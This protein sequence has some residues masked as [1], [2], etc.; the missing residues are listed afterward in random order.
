MT[1]LRQRLRAQVMEISGGICEWPLCSGRGVEL[2]HLHSVGAGGR[3]SADTL[4]NV[5]AF[6]WDHARISDGEFGQGGMDQY[7]EAHRVLFGAAQWQVSWP[8]SPGWEN[9]LAWERAE[10]LRIYLQT[11]RPGI[12]G[13]DQ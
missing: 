7:R 2:A 5:A 1:T 4:G 11:V 9:S 10:A 6:C 13:G 8:G 3:D 12:E